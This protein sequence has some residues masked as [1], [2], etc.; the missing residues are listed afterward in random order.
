VKNFDYCAQWQDLP[1]CTINSNEVYNGCDLD[2]FKVLLDPIAKICNGNCSKAC[3]ALINVLLTT[4]CWEGQ[5]EEYIKYF[6]PMQVNETLSELFGIVDNC[7]RVVTQETVQYFTSAPPQNMSGI[8]SQQYNE[9]DTQ[10]TTKPASQTSTE[11]ALPKPKPNSCQPQQTNP[12]SAMRLFGIWQN[13]IFSFAI[14]VF[15]LLN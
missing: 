7:S 4:G 10:K 6:W 3:Q 9:S 14:F 8:S 13:N 2:T 11:A 15:F 5:L 12:N 1:D